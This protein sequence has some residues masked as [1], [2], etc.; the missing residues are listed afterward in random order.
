MHKDLGQGVLE[1][2]YEVCFC[3]E[4]TKRGLQYKRHVDIPITYDSLV[5]DEGLRPDVFVEGMTICELKAVHEMNPVWQAQI[6]S[7]LKL[8]SKHLGFLINFN[9]PIFKQG[10]KRFII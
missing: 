6:Q 5:F 4:R 2:I 9:I 3:H 8:T 10:I 7:H 1:K